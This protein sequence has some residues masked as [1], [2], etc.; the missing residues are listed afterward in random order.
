MAC[1]SPAPNRLWWKGRLGFRTVA[2]GSPGWRLQRPLCVPSASEF[3]LE[4]REAGP[5]HSGLRHVLR[6]T[7]PRCAGTALSPP[8]TRYRSWSPQRLPLAPSAPG[9]RAA[10]CRRSANGALSIPCLRKH[11][12]G[13]SRLH[14]QGS[15]HFFQL[16]RTEVL[17]LPFI[18][19]FLTFCV[20]SRRP[21]F[22]GVGGK[23]GLGM[24]R[25]TDDF[26]SNLT[27]RVC[28]HGVETPQRATSPSSPR[29]H[30]RRALP[31]PQR[32][33]AVSSRAGN[34]FAHP[35]SALGSTRALSAW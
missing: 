9:H 10:S 26:I 27:P 1:L 5:L 11:G 18:K 19:P 24:G 7:G 21:A 35:Q 28:E 32:T 29:A 13:T 34:I 14:F 25:P 3:S 8:L 20:L 17:E 31:C 33:E 22:R 16:S 30:E 4:R 6:H 23:S 15:G 2:P 12:V